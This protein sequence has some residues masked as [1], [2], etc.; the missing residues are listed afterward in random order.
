MTHAAA[1]GG[2]GGSETGRRGRWPDQAPEK[3]LEM[4]RRCLTQKGIMK[5][6]NSE[7]GPDSVLLS[8]QRVLGP[9]LLPSAKEINAPS[10]ISLAVFVANADL[11]F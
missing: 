6:Q 9:V 4:H 5:V 7:D 10:L 8:I 1:R 2:G 3:D 11:T